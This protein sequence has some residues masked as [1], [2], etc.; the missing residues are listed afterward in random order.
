MSDRSAEDRPAPALYERLEA[1]VR[2]RAAMLADIGDVPAPIQ[3]ALT[4]LAAG[5]T[6][7]RAVA[8]GHEAFR[9]LLHDM[10]EGRV[11][12]LVAAGFDVAQAATFSDL[13]TPNFM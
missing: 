3:D 11:K 12:R 7:P 9:E 2:R 8:R 1:A 6:G 10:R 13:H 5:D 4:I